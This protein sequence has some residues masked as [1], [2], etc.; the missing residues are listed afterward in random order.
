MEQPSSNVII[1]GASSG[2]GLYAAK[3]LA[4]RGWHVIMACRNLPKT[5]QVAREVGIAPESRTIIKLDLA[6]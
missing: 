3:S 2:G 6:S 1:T 5:E 4:N